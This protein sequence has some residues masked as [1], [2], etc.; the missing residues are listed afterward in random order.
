MYVCNAH[1]LLQAHTYT[2]ISK[3][4]KIVLQGFQFP[5]ELLKNIK[6]QFN[7]LKITLT[8]LNKEP[9]K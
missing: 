8:I 1:K 6:Y 5:Q 9:P 4:F 7:E 3:T 2:Q